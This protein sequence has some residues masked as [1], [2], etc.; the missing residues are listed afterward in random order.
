MSVVASVSSQGKQLGTLFVSFYLFLCYSYLYLSVGLG[1]ELGAFTLSYIPSN[2]NKYLWGF[3]F[4]VFCS[5]TETPSLCSRL[6]LKLTV[7]PELALSS[8]PA[9]LVS[10]CWYYR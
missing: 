10:E 2:K 6:D 5:E 9:A 1:L 4:P 8:R 7:K 3:F